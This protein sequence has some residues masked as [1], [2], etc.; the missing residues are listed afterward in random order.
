MTKTPKPPSAEELR[1]LDYC[2]KQDFRDHRVKALVGILRAA[3]AKAREPLER[4]ISSLQ[5]NLDMSNEALELARKT[6]GPWDRPFLDDAISNLLYRHAELEREVER[7]RGLYN[8]VG[9]AVQRLKGQNLSREQW[10]AYLGI[11]EA[12]TEPIDPDYEAAR[13]E[14]EAKGR[15]RALEECWKAT[16]ILC[17]QGHEPE[18]RE[19]D[20]WWHVW[21]SG[22]D[23]YERPCLS[24]AIRALAQQ[25]G[26][27]ES[28]AGEANIRRYN[29]RVDRGRGRHG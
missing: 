13:A 20:G 28:D 23:L 24:S 2:V 8:G 3:E 5:T 25:D 26:G 11:V 19:K 10:E 29:Q 4:R 27:E 16:C 18:Y 21:K 22:A 12:Y 1:L 17:R 6:L 9:E 15:Q 7:L 14:G